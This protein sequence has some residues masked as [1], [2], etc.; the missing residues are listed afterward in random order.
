MAKTAKLERKK[1]QEICP[2]VRKDKKGH[3][4]ERV[5][6][7]RKTKDKLGTCSSDPVSGHCMKNP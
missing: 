7:G 3:G 6:S 4:G 5:N 1:M 2:P